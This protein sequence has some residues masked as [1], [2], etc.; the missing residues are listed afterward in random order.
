MPAASSAER[1]LAT[2]EQHVGSLVS[3]CRQLMEVNQTLIRD[4]T[5]LQAR[6]HELRRKN[7]QASSEIEKF[8]R[9][10]KSYD[11]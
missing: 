8:I 5:K 9:K 6:N 4:H 10:L 7:E 2:L 1:T 11:E 3:L